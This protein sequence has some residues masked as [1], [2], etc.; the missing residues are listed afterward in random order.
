MSDSGT[1]AYILKLVKP[2]TMVSEREEAIIEE[3]FEYLKKALVAGKL[4]LAGRCS[5]IAFGIVIFKADREEEANEF[6]RDD[7]AVKKG[8]MTAELHPFRLSLFKKH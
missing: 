1:Y 5:D 2:E 4:F 7:P 3:H 8:V 6:A